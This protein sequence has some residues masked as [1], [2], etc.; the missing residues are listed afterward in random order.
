[1]GVQVPTREEANFIGRM[2]RRPCKNSWTDGAAVW[3]DESHGEWWGGP[4][5]SHWR[6][7]ANMV[8]R[9]CSAVIGLATGGHLPKLLQAILFITDAEL[10]SPYD[11]WA[12]DLYERTCGRPN[13][14]K[15]HLL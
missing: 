13:E 7:L 1:M 10:R 14:A 9:L 5:E 4:R 2:R 3:D 6:H 11:S 8:E 12:Y 15:H